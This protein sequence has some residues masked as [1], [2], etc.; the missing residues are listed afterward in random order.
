MNI[1][2]DS[3]NQAFRR[4]ATYTKFLF[5]CLPSCF[6]GLVCVS[7]YQKIKGVQE[8]SAEENIRDLRE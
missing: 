5:S 3:Q 6:Y 4:H 8:Q 7:P 1:R 2:V